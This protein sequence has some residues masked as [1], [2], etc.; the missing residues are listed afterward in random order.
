MRP[1]PSH[2]TG[3]ALCQSAV[4]GSTW[5]PWEGTWGWDFSPEHGRGCA[6]AWRGLWGG[7]GA[8]AVEGLEPTRGWTAMCEVR[9]NMRAGWAAGRP[10]WLGPDRLSL[11]LA[12]PSAFPTF[13]HPSFKLFIHLCVH[14]L[15]PA[16][17]KN[18]ECQ[19]HTSHPGP[20]RP[21]R[22]S[23]L[24][25]RAPPQADRP[26][27][28]RG[29]CRRE[30]G[31]G[32]PRRHC[33]SPA[34]GLCVPGARRCWGLWQRWWA[35]GG[36]SGERAVGVDVGPSRPRSLHPVS[37]PWPLLAEGADGDCEGFWGGEKAN[38]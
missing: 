24:G 14:S 6:A 17:N 13:V 10:S 33:P 32:P 25:H 16:V 23:C 31:A 38:Q 22:A 9:G 20:R 1:G 26:R 19:L 30:D 4:G 11:G 5:L 7:G 8:G 3:E 21:E 36:A 28:A 18:S 15:I 12:V 27:T 29:L 34:H 2:P 37:E 35:C